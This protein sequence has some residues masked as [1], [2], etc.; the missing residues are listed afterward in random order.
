MKRF[1]ATPLLLALIGAGCPTGE[2]AAVS[3]PG[4][5]E[6]A[7]P[8]A[9]D[10]VFGN[11]KKPP[12]Y[13]SNTPAHG[14]I[15]PAPPVNV[16]IDVNFDLAAP[17]AIRIEKDGKDYGSGPTIIDKNALAMRRAMDQGAPDGLYR[18]TY[19]ACWPDRSCHEGRFEFALDRAKAPGYLDLRGQTEATVRLSEVQFSP[20]RVRVSRGTKVIWVN[21]EEIEHYVNTD[22][23]PAHTYFPAQN[24][25]L[26]KKGDT[27]S[28]TFESPGTYPYHCSAHAEAMT[29]EIL[30]E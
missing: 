24:S 23:H 27:Y 8:E 13:E 10:P 4:G 5:S 15:L 29:G 16:V 7:V 14:A 21:D 22:S 28:V 3:G 30:V 26:L 2:Q 17:S 18:V 11:P 9:P 6:A 1:L 19:D 20:M 25:R 12:H